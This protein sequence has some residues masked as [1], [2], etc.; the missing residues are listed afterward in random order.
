MT[1]CRIISRS[2]DGTI[3]KAWDCRLVSASENRLE[4]V[5]AFAHEIV[6]SELGTI[7]AG[8]ASHEYY[9]IDRWYNIFR[10]V[11]P[12]GNLRNYYCNVN[13][14]PVFDGTILDYVD[15]DL[16]LLVWPDGSYEILDRSE[17]AS[18]ALTLGYSPDVLANANAALASLVVLA[19]RGD[20][21]SILATGSVAELPHDTQ[22]IAADREV[23]SGSDS[24]TLT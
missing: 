1:E 24:D 21:E 3:K 9:W 4:F 5:G 17:F 6:H 11:T 16:D 13:M 22:D 2:Y 7:A 20:I 10:F 8:T 15:L 14:P 18:N 23:H 12:E 19:E